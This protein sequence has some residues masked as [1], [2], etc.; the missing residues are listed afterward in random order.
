MTPGQRGALL[1]IRLSDGTEKRQVIERDVILIGRDASCD[2]VLDS[3][4]VSRRHVVIRREVAGWTV[5][6]LASTN[7][8]MLND[9][10]LGSAP[11]PLSPDDAITV[12]PYEIRFC[13]SRGE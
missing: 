3:K 8:T 11:A 5:Q 10:L 9:G 13:P 2:V 1:H 6:D 7:G 4:R 12:S